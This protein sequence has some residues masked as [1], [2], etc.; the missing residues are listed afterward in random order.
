VNDSDEGGHDVVALILDLGVGEAEW[1]EAV[2]G[3]G[4]VA[5]S[6]GGLLG[7][8]AVVAAAVGLDDEAELGPEEVD[9]VAVDPDLG[10]GWW[11]SGLA[12]E[13]EE[14]PLELAVGQGEGLPV[15]QVSQALGARRSGRLGDLVQPFGWMRSFLSASLIAASSA[16]S[17]SCVARS[18]RVWPGGVVGMPWRCVLGR[19]ARR[20][21]VS[22]GR[23][24]LTCLGT[25][26]WIGPLR[27]WRISHSSPA[28]W[29][30]RTA[31]GPQLSTA[32]IHRPYRVSSGRP[33][34]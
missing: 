5:A 20:K 9:A 8:G 24:R 34:A 2:G 26:T 22:P 28:D 6:V 3:V 33:T 27:G 11:Q 1:G 31:S 4:L 15:E 13:G 7:G 12:G 29:W 16:L 21:R 18:I 32:A 23:W 30:L 14:A 25:E 17:S 10:L 19:T